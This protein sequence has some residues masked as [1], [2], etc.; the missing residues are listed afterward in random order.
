MAQ[1]SM[2]FIGA[3]RDVLRMTDFE[4]QEQTR[5]AVKVRQVQ[6]VSEK[7]IIFL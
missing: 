2:F 7:H 6:N 4:V 1:T 3:S 5:R